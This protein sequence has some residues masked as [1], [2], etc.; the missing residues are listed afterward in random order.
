MKTLHLNLKSKW[1]DMIASGE[2]KEEYRDDC[3]YWAKR[4]LDFKGQTGFPACDALDTKF[5]N[6]DTVTFSN[7]YRWDRR[8]M[9]VEIKGM[10]FGDGKEEWGAIRHKWCFIIKLG[11]IISKNF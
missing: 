5:K 8:Q 6:F 10:D 4:L 9:V 1:F 3:D 2:K 11:N 7:G